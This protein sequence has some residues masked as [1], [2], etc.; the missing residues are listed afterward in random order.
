M[1]CY[2]IIK[3]KKSAKSKEGCRVNKRQLYSLGHVIR[4]QPG[5]KNYCMI[6]RLILIL[7]K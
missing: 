3:R 2:K 5:L 1:N 6:K 4:M 7:N